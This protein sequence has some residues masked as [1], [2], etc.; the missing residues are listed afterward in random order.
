MVT[1]SK[2]YFSRLLQ[3]YGFGMRNICSLVCNE[4]DTC[5][6]GKFCACC[7]GMLSVL[8]M[9]RNEALLAPVIFLYSEW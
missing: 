2:V 3:H 7:L 1:Y 6:L 9:R 4:D 8:S 5:T